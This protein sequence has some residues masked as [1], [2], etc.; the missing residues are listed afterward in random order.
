MLV[1]EPV[2]SETAPTVSEEAPR[3]SVP[4]LTVTEPVSGK[5]L[6]APEASTPPVIVVPPV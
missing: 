1:I 4:P 3:A 5:T 6:L 2:R